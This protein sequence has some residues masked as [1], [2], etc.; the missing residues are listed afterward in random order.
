MLH[1]TLLFMNR[2][3]K[4]CYFRLFDVFLASKDLSVQKV[5]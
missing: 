1:V 4:S 5:Y 3:S 2:L